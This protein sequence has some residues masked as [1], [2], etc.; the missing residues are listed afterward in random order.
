MENS[1]QLDTKR[2]FSR[3][4]VSSIEN[5]NEI[6]H[7]NLLCCVCLEIALQP[8]ECPNCEVL[9]CS[10]CSD[11]LKINNKICVK[12]KCKELRK[13][14]KFARE[15][16]SQ[17]KLKCSFC[18]LENIFSYDNYI[19]HLK[20]CD[21]YNDLDIFKKI[22]QT[23]ELENQVQ[24]LSA[25]KLKLKKEIISEDK[26]LKLNKQGK[27]FF[28]NDLIDITSILN[29]S[30]KMELYN[31]TIEGDVK[32]FKTLIEDKNYPIFEEISAE[33]YNW[34]SLHYAMHYGKESII[35]YILDYLNKRNSLHLGIKKKSSDGRCPLLCMIKSNTLDTSTKK[36]LLKKLFD[37]Y[38]NMS[39]DEIVLI[40]VKR[41]GME[42][43][44]IR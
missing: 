26:K 22:K 19:E 11:M 3:L 15:M 38:N 2:I 35:Y 42:D 10:I 6:M 44:V 7:Q 23:L 34:T 13:A 43:I 30:Q 41:R 14:N 33:G 17:I 16:L 21:V 9:I 40:E 18:K 27:K 29:S 5:K 24:I 31:S 12:D 25:E 8:L 4:L 20:K 1:N 37:R 28:D 36:V 32:K 39:I